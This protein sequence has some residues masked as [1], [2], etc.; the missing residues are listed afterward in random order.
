M[1]NCKQVVNDHINLSIIKYTDCDG[2]S[3]N[4]QDGNESTY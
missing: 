3:L 4:L 2:L 1:D